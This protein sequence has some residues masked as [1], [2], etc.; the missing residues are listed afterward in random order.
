[1][2]VNAGGEATNEGADGVKFLSDTFFDGGNV[3]L[4]NEAIVEGGDYPSIYQSAR[5]G[6][7]SYRIDNLPPGQY[8]VDLHFVEIINVNG[9]KGMRVFNVYIQEEKVSFFT[10]LMLLHLRNL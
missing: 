7:F 3:F 1:M 2:F 9:P 6:S 10:E 5:V 4:T 8:L